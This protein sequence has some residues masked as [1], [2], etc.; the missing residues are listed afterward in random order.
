MLPGAQV[1]TTIVL[2]RAYIPSRSWPSSSARGA[3]W[4]CGRCWAT[5][6]RSRAWLRL[7]VRQASTDAPA[8]AR[9]LL[10]VDQFE[11]TFTLCRDEAERRGFILTLA[12]LTSEADNQA[13]VILGVRADFYARCAEYPELVAAVQDRHVL[14]SPMTVGSCERRSRGQRL[15]PDWCWSPGWSRSCWPIWVRGR[16]RCR[17]CHTRLLATWQRREGDT[18][19]IEGYR[20][21]RGIR[22]AIGRTADA[23]YAL[24]D[25]AQ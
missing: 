25:P 7:A 24:F 10:L 17:Y 15:G 23:V 1:W 21:A 12:G 22:Q 9:L 4:P 19:T 13:I 8:G 11:E 18:L 14:I 20:E 6:K 16:D 5:G 2:T 3:T